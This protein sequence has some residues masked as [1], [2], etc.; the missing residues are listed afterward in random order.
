[1]KISS[2]NNENRHCTGKQVNFNIVQIHSHISVHNNCFD[3]VIA[4]KNGS[5]QMIVNTKS[6]WVCKNK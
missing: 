1:M 2:T 3:C 6:D 4:V 5:F